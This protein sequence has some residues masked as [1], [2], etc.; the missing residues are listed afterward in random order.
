MIEVDVSSGILPQHRLVLETLRNLATKT[1]ADSWVLVGGLMVLVI[2]AEHD[3]I[4]RRSEGTK[5][6]DVVVDL[7]SRPDMLHR[8]TWSLQEMGF[9]LADRIGRGDTRVARCTYCFGSA[10]IDVLCPD[11]T[12]PDLLSAD[13]GVASI[14]IPGGRLAIEHSRVVDV[15][16]DHEQSSAEIRVPTLIGAL[17]TKALA[18]LDPRT[19]HQQRHLQDVAFLLSILPNP[20]EVATTLDDASRRLIASLPDLMDDQRP[21]P[22]WDY[23]TPAERRTA[24]S[25]H[26]LLLADRAESP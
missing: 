7:I 6:A 15:L 23:L 4:G 21:S 17:L 26:R 20:I 22:A 3:A 9:E 11:G 16:F 13:N 5:D 12:P 24:V 25:A 8:M 18:V 10:T 19:S 1:G 2:A 14:A